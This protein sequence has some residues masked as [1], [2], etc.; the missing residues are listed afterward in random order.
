MLVCGALLVA[1]GAIQAAGP[2]GSDLK[3]WSNFKSWT[4]SLGSDGATILTS[5]VI[6]TTSGWDELIASWNA[7][8]P[9]G[10]GLRVEARALYPDRETKWYSLGLWSESGH[11]FPRTSVRG[12]KDDD[13]DVATDTLK[14]TN[15]AWRVQVRVALVPNR[16]EQP[17]LRFLAISLWSRDA[18][19]PPLEPNRRAWGVKLDVP[20]L[21]QGDFP[22]G[23]DSWC[24]PTST[25]MVLGYWSRERKKVDWS[26]TVPEVA[27]GVMDPAWPGT[28][29]WSF[30][31]AY[32]GAI[33]GLRAYVTR[34]TDVAEL[35]DWIAAG[36][37]VVVS[38]DYDTLRNKPPGRDSGHLMV[39][40]GFTGAGDP[41]LN[42][43]GSRENQQ[44]AYAR[45]D[46]TKAWDSSHRTVYLIHPE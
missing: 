2:R 22:G 11:G 41:I 14:L 42:D 37:P 18:S 19:Q 34:L 43:P 16:W 12:Q 3:T 29:N 31:V 35:E 44:R 4:R 15:S 9:G 5:P 36:V 45:L 20:N 21:L 8:T 30:N 13:G 46:F 1:A 10:T 17:S 7:T 6:R 33:P 27:T 25:A 32:A 26:R 40:V 39:V 24:S 28:G 23:E 38:L